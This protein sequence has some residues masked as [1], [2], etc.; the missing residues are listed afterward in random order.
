MP[1]PSTNSFELRP[2]LDLRWT[3]IGL[4]LDL[5]WTNRINNKQK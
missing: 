4:T 3:Y 5:H 1:K 2:T